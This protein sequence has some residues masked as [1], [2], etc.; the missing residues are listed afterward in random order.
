MSIVFY[1]EEPLRLLCTDGKE[2]S[3]AEYL[4]TEAEL[5]SECI[6]QADGWLSAPLDDSF[7]QRIYD[8]AVADSV[9]PDFRLIHG[10]TYKDRIKRAKTALHMS[11]DKYMVCLSD[12]SAFCHEGQIVSLADIISGKVKPTWHLTYTQA[13]VAAE[14]MRLKAQEAPKAKWLCVNSQQ[15]YVML[16]KVFYVPVEVDRDRLHVNC[17][18]C[19]SGCDV[20]F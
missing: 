11:R 13:Y 9:M 7:Y 20:A 4:N 15:F 19:R 5:A 18:G 12:L 17:A 2:L 8:E 3:V 14:Q 6:A 10:E 1:R 16:A